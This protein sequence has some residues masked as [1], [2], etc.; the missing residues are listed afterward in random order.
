M[1]HHCIYVRLTSIRLLAK[2]VQ[3]VAI[4]QKKSQF[5]HNYPLFTLMQNVY[6]NTLC[7]SKI[8]S[9]MSYFWPTLYKFTYK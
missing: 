2:N 3:I 1:T 6:F 8:Y 5:T 4:Q 9:R 7:L